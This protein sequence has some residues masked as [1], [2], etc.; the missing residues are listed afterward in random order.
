MGQNHSISNCNLPTVFFTYSNAI[1]EGQTS[2]RV[3]AN[4]IGQ[5]FRL[6]AKPDD[7]LLEYLGGGKEYPSG[8][9][10]TRDKRVVVGS[11]MHDHVIYEVG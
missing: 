2:I 4:N 3:L 11:K 7:V 6:T 1:S 10:L 8:L 9:V 5:V